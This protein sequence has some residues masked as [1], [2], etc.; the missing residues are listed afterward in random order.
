MKF[1]L[2]LFTLFVILFNLGTTNTFAVDSC[3][4]ANPCVIGFKCDGGKCV[5][6]EGDEENNAFGQVFCKMFK[7]LTGSIGRGVAAA[8]IIWAGVSFFLGKISWGAICAIGLAIGF[9]FG[10]PSIVKVLT[11]KGL[12]CGTKT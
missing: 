4:D 7:F 9:I 12:E 3:S 1:T 10:A 2:K 5:V 11:G 8:A 6:Y